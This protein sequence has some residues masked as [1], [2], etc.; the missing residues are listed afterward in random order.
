MPLNLDSAK[1]ALIDLMK[2]T[3]R[4]ERLP[5]D[6]DRILNESTGQYDEPASTILY[7]GKAMI[8]TNAQEPRPRDYGAVTSDESLYTCRWPAEDT[9]RVRRDDRVIV[10][11]SEDAQ[12]LGLE[13]RI[14]QEIHGTYA[15]SRRVHMV[16]VDQV[17]D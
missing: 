17:I 3:V 12:L 11:E 4:I 6:A 13:F 8:S 1:V 14:E 2:D 16:L 15:V 7:V 10:T 5:R 9:V